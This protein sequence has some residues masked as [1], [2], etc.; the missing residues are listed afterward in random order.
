[1][2]NFTHSVACLE[3]RFTDDHCRE[4]SIA[5]FQ[6]WKREYFAYTSRLPPDNAHA[7]V[8]TEAGIIPL[9]LRS[10]GAVSYGE[11]RLSNTVKNGIKKQLQR[12]RQQQ[13]QLGGRLYH[14]DLVPVG[15]AALRGLRSAQNIMFVPRL[16][17]VAI[18]QT[19]GS[20][21]TAAGAVAE[22]IAPPPGPGSGLEESLAT[23]YCIQ[24]SA[25]L[26]RCEQLLFGDDI[27]IMPDPRY[28]D[29]NLANAVTLITVGW[30]TE[31]QQKAYNL[32][33]DGP[34]VRP[35]DRNSRLFCNIC[36]N[37]C[38]P[39]LLDICLGARG[40]DAPELA[41]G[42]IAPAWRNPNSCKCHSF[43]R[44]EDFFFRAQQQSP[45]EAAGQDAVQHR[46]GRSWQ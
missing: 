3:T 29:K 20:S 46:P 7:M 40:D 34:R 11:E 31:F 30:L 39:I 12:Q 21:N 45:V 23:V 24:H 5:H 43:L 38:P 16:L 10:P 25:D 41:A 42:P 4:A 15:G 44:G 27:A 32:A 28:G 18:Q 22:S 37:S 19:R 17:P 14:S 13:Q 35:Y 2:D 6:G 1:M 36:N 33:F 8:V 9:K 26:K